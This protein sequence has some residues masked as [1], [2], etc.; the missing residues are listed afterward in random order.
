[1]AAQLFPEDRSDLRQQC[2]LPFFPGDLFSD[3]ICSALY[4]FLFF[5][6][7]ASIYGF[8]GCRGYSGCL[9]TCGRCA[10][11]Q[12]VVHPGLRAVSLSLCVIVRHLLGS[13]LGPPI[14]GALSDAYGLERAMV[15]LPVFTLPA[16]RL[17]SIGAFSYTDNAGRF[18]I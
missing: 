7:Q 13:A 2:R 10:V 11:T 17:F 9:R 1:M 4:R 18:G 12:N 15:F 5:S 16:L 8:A 14:I 6:G 3:G